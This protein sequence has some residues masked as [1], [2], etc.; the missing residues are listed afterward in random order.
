MNYLFASFYYEI[1]I[2]VFKT[3]LNQIKIELNCESKNWDQIELWG[4]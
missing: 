4:C 1:D 2:E 3:I